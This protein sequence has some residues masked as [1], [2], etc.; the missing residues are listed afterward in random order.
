MHGTGEHL[1]LVRFRRPKV[2]CFLSH[3]EYRPNTNQQ[4]YEKQV[5][6]RGGHI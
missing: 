3:V 6:V 2:A 4:Y 1:K 5:T